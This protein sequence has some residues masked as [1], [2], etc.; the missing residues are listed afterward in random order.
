MKSSEE[1]RPI[2]YKVGQLVVNNKLGLGRVLR[3]RGDDV[4][5]FFKDQT[6]NP[7]TINVVYMPMAISKEQSDA[8]LDSPDMLKKQKKTLPGKKRPVRR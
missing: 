2:R 8:C 3:I 7:R 4:T 6:D 5:V 1:G